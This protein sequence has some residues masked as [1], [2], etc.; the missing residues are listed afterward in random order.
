ML[1]AAHPP[2]AAIVLAA[3]WGIVVPVLLVGIALVTSPQRRAA[4]VDAAAG[5][6]ATIALVKL[7]AHLYAHPRPFVVDHIAPLVAHAADNAF[8]SD[9]AAAAG[10]AVAY[11]WPRSR[12]FAAIAAAFAVVIGVARVAAHLHW[13]ID[14]VAGYGFG[15]VGAGLGS[16]LVR[17][18][19]PMA[20]L[21]PA[22]DNA[23]FQGVRKRS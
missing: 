21:G 7:G 3:A 5:G 6:L 19:S 4:F 15:L 14:I 17:R 18:F 16:Y 9:H 2:D 23:A 12:S 20:R 13:P 11:L 8:P 1:S 22:H 10:L